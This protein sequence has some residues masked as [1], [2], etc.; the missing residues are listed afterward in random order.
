MGLVETE[1]TKEEK[2]MGLLLSVL[3]FRSCSLV[4]GREVD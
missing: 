2:S 4:L 1:G 3:V